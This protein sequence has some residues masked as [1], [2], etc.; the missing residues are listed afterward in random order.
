MARIPRVAKGD[1]R[2]LIDA[3][4]F[5]RDLACKKMLTEAGQ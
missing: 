3:R 2:L 4:L 5:F 1:L